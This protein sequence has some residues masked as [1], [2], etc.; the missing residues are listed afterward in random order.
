MRTRLTNYKCSGPL[1]VFNLRRL[2]NKSGVFFSSGKRV[3]NSE[4]CTELVY[5][6][7]DFEDAQINIS[8][9]HVQNITFQ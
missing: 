5:S 2:F 1:R 6:V 8:L 9:P 4:N 7:I 3:Y